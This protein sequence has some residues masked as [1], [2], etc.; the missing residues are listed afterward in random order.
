[1]TPSISA[2]HFFGIDV[3]LFRGEIS[4]VFLVRMTEKLDMGSRIYVSKH[5]GLAKHAGHLIKERGK[6]PIKV[7]GKADP[8]LPLSR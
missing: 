5:V 1:M 2:V 3:P 4:I 7:K 8:L 6:K